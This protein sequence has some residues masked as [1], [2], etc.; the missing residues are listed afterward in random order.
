MKWDP[1][2]NKWVKTNSAKGTAV[3]QLLREEGECL[4]DERYQMK[5]ATN[6]WAQRDTY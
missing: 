3:L 1:L 5:M 4:N 6:S 2:E